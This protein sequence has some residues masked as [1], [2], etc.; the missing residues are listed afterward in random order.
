MEILIMQLL[1]EIV[2]I[3]FSIALFINALLFIP[4]IV[5]LWRNKHA[6]DVSLITFA[7]FNIINI[8]TMLHGFTIH[9]RLLIIGYS[10][11]VFTNT[12]VTGLIVWYRYIS[13]LGK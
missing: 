11:S 3:I 8:F 10:F 9:D 2:N 12:I 13:R 4:Q 5:A 7:G 6:N 1:N